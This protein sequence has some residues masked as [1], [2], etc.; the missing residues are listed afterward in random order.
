[1][2]LC[3]NPIY[4]DQILNYKLASN[5]TVELAKKA[6]SN[7]KLSETQKQE[8]LF[9]VGFEVGGNL[10]NK[11]WRPNRYIRD[12]VDFY[13]EKEFKDNF[14]IGIQ[15]RYFYLNRLFDTMK[16]ID[17]ALQIENEHGLKNNF[18][19]NSKFRWFISSDTQSHID[20]LLIVYGDR[21]F[22]VNGTI[23]HINDDPNGYEKA[24]ID[25]ELLSRCDEI[26]M[27]G[28][29]TFGFVAAMKNM[30]LPYFVNGKDSNM[31]TCLRHSLAY[32]GL[33]KTFNMD[34][35]F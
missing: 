10:L 33:S 24:I 9:K 5:E 27:T 23:T 16:F 3:C 15:L 4:Y 12:K 21:L 31:T 17:C 28:G 13:L 6:V 14:V 11:F 22:T 34:A 29:S 1:M 19:K 35:V 30:K 25:V 2:E 18:N 8:Y 32:P 26:I 7:K 20:E